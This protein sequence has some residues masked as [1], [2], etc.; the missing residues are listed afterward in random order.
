MGTITK[1][2]LGGFSGKVGSVVGGTW[3]GID[4]MRSKG[5]RSNRA[6][7]QRQLQQQQKF[8]VMMKFTQPLAGLLM[9]SFRNFA[10]KM[11]GTNSSFSYN[12][13]NAIT[14]TYPDYEVAYNLA[15][16]SRGDMPNAT[17]PSATAGTTGK[18][19]FTWVNNAGTGKAA[20]T[21]P[22]IAVAFC[23]GINQAVYTTQGNTRDQQST[24][25]DAG[26]FSGKVVETWLAFISADGKEVA[27]SIYTGPV[28]VP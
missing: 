8:A 26:V 4:Y 20:D 3:K 28:T 15:L 5:N 23:P 10:V 18:V 7:T 21:D 9:V 14:G 19:N 1:G 17:S 25:L 27:T 13:K 11:T 2:I 24:I 6:A 12:L 22:S 16:V